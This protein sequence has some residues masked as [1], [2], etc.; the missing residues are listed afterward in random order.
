MPLGSHVNAQKGLKV[1][2]V[3]IKRV[4]NLLNANFSCSGDIIIFFKVQLVRKQLVIVLWKLSACPIKLP[5]VSINL[6]TRAT[7]LVHAKTVSKVTS[8]KRILT[9]VRETLVKTTLP[10]WMESMII[11][12]NVQ[13]S[14]L[15]RIVL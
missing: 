11:R 6:R 1:R 4:L 9:N 10:V 2:L 15:E 12:V 13:D 7:I 5:I 14:L 3:F 8:A